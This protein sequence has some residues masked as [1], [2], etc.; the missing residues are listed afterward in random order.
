MSYAHLSQIITFSQI[1]LTPYDTVLYKT[2]FLSQSENSTTIMEACFISVFISHFSIL[3]LRTA[4]SI[5]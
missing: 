4:T 1:Y 5:T 2:Q 3:V